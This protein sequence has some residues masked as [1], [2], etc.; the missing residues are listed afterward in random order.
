MLC[1]WSSQY[2]HR[3]IPPDQSRS[4]YRAEIHIDQISDVEGAER[5][6]FLVTPKLGPVTDVETNLREKPGT[7]RKVIVFN[8]A[9]VSVDRICRRM[10]REREE[11]H[12]GTRPPPCDHRCLRSTG[13]AAGGS[14]PDVVRARWHILVSRPGSWSATT[15]HGSALITRY[16]C[17]LVNMFPFFQ[18]ADFGRRQFVVFLRPKDIK[19]G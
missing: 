11:Q 16:A 10:G 13:A 5:Q 1:A 9:H 8:L 17:S 14:R 6:S 4:V 15:S 18:E 7:D 2:P 12:R 19:S 3:P